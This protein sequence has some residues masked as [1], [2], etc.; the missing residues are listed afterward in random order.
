MNT[1]P[2]KQK[3]F[4]LYGMPA[5][6]Y[7]A[8]VRSYLR[9]QG[10]LFEERGAGDPRFTKEILP[11]TKRW[12]IPVLQT[13][14]GE[15]IQDGACIIDQLEAGRSTDAATGPSAAPA[16]PILRVIAHVF[17]MFGGEGLLRP[18]MHYRWNFDATN[19]PFIKPDFLSALAPDQVGEDAE[20][21][22]AV[23]SDRMRKATRMFG[24]TSETMATVEAS[25]LEFLH[26]LN[27]HLR[28]TPYVLGN[29]PTYADYGLIGP[30]SA[31]LG[32][33]PYPSVLMKQQAPRVWR[34]V[35]RM[36]A[37]NVDC[38]E[39]LS[40]SADWTSPPNAS[41]TLKALLKYI[42]QEFLPEL[43]A[44]VEFANQWLAQQPESIE[45]SNGMPKPSDRHIGTTTVQWRGFAIEIMV[46][47][48]RIFM[49][50]RVQDCVAALNSQQRI[51]MS[52]LLNECQ[53][54]PLLDMQCK[55]RV[56]RRG[57]LEVWG[58]PS[59]YQ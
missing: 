47:P 15:T 51:D 55:R 52:A 6:L 59:P 33:D 21:I 39:Y 22:F 14:Q 42:A 13:P 20:R 41:E 45:G 25:Y 7:T 54:S 57:L 30:L 24:V 1:V 16:D 50:Q 38:G 37:P 29:T 31:H 5:S 34:W 53:L 27:R 56:E 35:E 32:R 8:K 4:V 40:P 19:L 28:D 12:I 36:N 46:M 2:Q 3:S 43:Q 9:K 18:A 26:L 23:A 48:Y 11:L 10:I 44:Q 49:L 58:A 17:E